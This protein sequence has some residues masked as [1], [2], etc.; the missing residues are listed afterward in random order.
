MEAPAPTTNVITGPPCAGKSSIISEL[1]ARGY[2]TLP[3]A[4]R[5]YFRQRES[6]GVP[7]NDVRENE[8]FQEKIENRRIEM[9]Q[10][11]PADETVFLDR[12]IPDNIAY[13]KHFNTGDDAYLDSL[14][15]RANNRYDR[16]FL[17][18]QLEYEQDHVRDESPEEAREIAQAIK[19]TYEQL[20]YTIF[21]VPVMPIEKRA[22]YIE[23]FTKITAIH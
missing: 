15:E 12:A 19:N 10:N 13:R 9:E 2:Y 22:N 8:D 1:S 3:E 17:L 16:V 6:D 21:E 11:I 23:K 18:E 7:P 4:A 5:L 20:G 14:R